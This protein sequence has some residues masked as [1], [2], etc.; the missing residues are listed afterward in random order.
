MQD[1]NDN[2]LGSE[3]T[4]SNGAEYSD[5]SSRA[6]YRTGEARRNAWN[7][8]RAE[9]SKSFGSSRSLANG[10]EY[11]RLL[12]VVNEVL[13]LTFPL[14][15]LFTPVEFDCFR[16][17]VSEALPELND[18]DFLAAIIGNNADLSTQ[19][20]IDNEIDAILKKLFFHAGGTLIGCLEP[21]SER[22][23]ES[24]RDYILRHGAAIGYLIGRP[25]SSPDDLYL[26]KYFHKY[27]DDFNAADHRLAIPL[28]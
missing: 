5:G 23:E 18:V 19:E 17:E 28:S 16:K 3:K 25:Q 21:H 1:D 24:V 14:K 13:N 9:S 11:R 27:L 26:A 4:S 2:F 20:K 7:R 10:D 22:T 15:T 6:F 8:D 12:R